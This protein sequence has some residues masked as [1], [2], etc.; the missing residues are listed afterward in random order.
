M[1]ATRVVVMNASLNVGGAERTLAD[2]ARR[3][4][5]RRFEVTVVCLYEAGPVGEALRS[6]GVTVVDRVLRH[7]ADVRGFLRLVSLLRRLAPHV[8]Y[9]NN[10]PLTQLWGW[11]AAV[12]ARVRATVT[13]FHFASR[14]E[15]AGRGV[16][17]N[18]MLGRRV[19]A[20]VALSQAHKAY[21]SATERVPERKIVVIPNGIDVGAFSA[22]RDARDEVRSDLG[23]APDRT[24]VSIVAQLRPE[25]NHSMFL[26]AA[27]EVLG[28]GARV[29]FLV[30]GDGVERPRLERLARELGI[31]RDVRFLGTRSD[32][33]AV[34]AAS[35]VGVLCS[36]GEAFPLSV[37]E[38]MAAGRPVVSTEVGS[39]DEI[40]LP[41]ETGFL[42][43]RDD[44][45]ALAVKLE[46]LI[47][48]DGERKRLGDAAKR[49]VEE[50]F[51]IERMV[52]RTEALLEDV[53]GRSGAGATGR[54]TVIVVGPRLRLWGGVNTH[55][56]TL[57][58]GGLNEAFDLVH[59]EVGFYEESASRA[60][61]LI[62]G[63]RK[64]AQLRKLVARRPG[65]VVHLNPSMDT[66]SLIRDLPMVHV[67]SRRGARVVVQFHGGL[68]DRPKP[69]RYGWVR[70]AVLR[71]LERADLVVVLSRLQARSISSTLG[72]SERMKIQ[73]VPLFLDLQPF[74]ARRRE[75]PE[76]D[77]PRSFVF[78][79]R[80]V[81]EK[82]VHELV[83]AVA[84]LRSDGLD[85][86][87][88]IAGAGPDESEMRRRCDALG[89]GGAVTW[90]GYLG[91]ESKL[92]LLARSDVF[93]LASSWLEGLPNALLEAMAMGLPVIV[94]DVGAMAEV[95]EDGVNGFLVPAGDA[96]AL[97]DK[98]AYLVRHGSEAAAMGRRNSAIATA[99]FGLDSQVTTWGDI[100]TRVSRRSAQ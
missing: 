91:T 71:T 99:R 52:E 65:A 48:D 2:L 68:M 86:V 31:E 83:A 79:G 53:T 10:Q 35:D 3:L 24:V 87:A 17:L 89:V 77:L 1:S 94:S 6:E 58:S 14:R 28:R 66:R 38:F 5:R 73:Q 93:V 40:V 72:A 47:T 42:V 69:M 62:D 23:I 9:Y 37:L 43:P 78:V 92:D 26:R 59:L 8:L 90:H 33:P 20:C 15:K 4:D 63:L 22:A 25:K 55:V 19:D 18:R 61:R 7:K 54:Q 88:D 32:V 64:I 85:V 95:V 82:G 51:T 70:R 98:M 75:R 46:R 34:M 27:R 49:R 39:V 13:V 76:R 96:G 80:L 57:L 67:A 97:A 30:V 16:L 36:F 60:K 84:A 100:Y 11:T 41:G 74:E 45:A 21:V 81:R 56:R 44:A 50:H 29:T 12:L